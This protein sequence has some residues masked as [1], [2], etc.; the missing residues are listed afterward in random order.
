MTLSYT[1][2]EVLNAF[3]ISSKLGLAE[4]LIEDARSRINK[5]DVVLAVIREDKKSEI[6]KYINDR[7]NISKNA[8]GIAF[9]I[10]VNSVMGVLLYRFLSDTKQNIRKG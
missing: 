2:G 6:F 1:S 4:D 5:K 9:T 7:F 3:A 10:K 8:K